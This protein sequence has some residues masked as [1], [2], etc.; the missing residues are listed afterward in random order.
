MLLLDHPLLT[1]TI[2][3]FFVCFIVLLQ[4]VRGEEIVFNKILFVYMHSYP[5]SPLG[6]SHVFLT[7]LI[8]SV[9]VYAHA[10]P[11]KFKPA[12]FFSNLKYG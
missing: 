10:N 9:R 7:S 3:S 5:D 1:T 4:K 8:T 12:Q 11:A 6:K 2:G